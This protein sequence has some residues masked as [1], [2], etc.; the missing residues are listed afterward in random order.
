MNKVIVSTCI[1]P[2]QARGGSLK[3]LLTKNKIRISAF[4]F[5]AFTQT[6]PVFADPVKKPESEISER[7]GSLIA[8]QVCSG[9][10]GKT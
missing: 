2:N 10:H 4:L 1:H 5:L 9:C 7:S 3:N 8:L 6:L